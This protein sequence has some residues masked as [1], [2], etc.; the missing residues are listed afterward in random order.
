MEVSEGIVLG[1]VGMKPDLGESVILRDI[2][3]F[4]EGVEQC[5]F[6]ATKILEREVLLKLW[7]PKM[8][9]M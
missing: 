3:S 1:C 2:K 5:W 7:L 6:T 4:V 8:N 9:K